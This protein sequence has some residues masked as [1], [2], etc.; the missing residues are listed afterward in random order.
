MQPA[1]SIPVW[2]EFRQP[3]GNGHYFYTPQGGNIYQNLSQTENGL[4][5]DNELYN[6][7]YHFDKEIFPSTHLGFVIDFYYDTINR[8]SMN[9]EGIYL[10]I[11]FG[12]SLKKAK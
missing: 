9:S 4:V 2:E 3:I 6:L 1:A 11:N 12:I 7:K 10:V 8:V 5:P